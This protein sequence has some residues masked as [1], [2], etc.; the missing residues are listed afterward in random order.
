FSSVILTTGFIGRV[1]GD[2]IS[3]IY[4]TIITFATALVTILLAVQAIIPGMN[5]WSKESNIDKR[6]REMRLVIRAN[7]G[8]GGFMSS[9][10]YLLVFSVCGWLLTKRLG[11]GLPIVVD[12]SIENNFAP[13]RS[14][15]DVLNPF[16]DQFSLSYE[17]TLISLST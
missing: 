2:F 7:K 10:F 17:Q 12:L 13:F 3:E 14:I 16:S 8:L 9:F 4:S 1:D 11:S 6:I 5:V 15:I